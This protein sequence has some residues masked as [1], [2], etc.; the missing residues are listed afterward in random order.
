MKILQPS[1]ELIKKIK[2]NKWV[3]IHIL[4]TFRKKLNQLNVYQQFLLGLV[5]LK[6]SHFAWTFTCF[7]L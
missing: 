1:A 4:Y 5:L 2:T 3:G 7:Q 6:H